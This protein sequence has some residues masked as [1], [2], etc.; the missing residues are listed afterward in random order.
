MVWWLV[1]CVKTGTQEEVAQIRRHLCER[2]NVLPRV[3]KSGRPRSTT[4][5]TEKD[6]LDVVNG[7]PRISPRRVSAR[8]GVAHF[9]VWRVLL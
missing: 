4:A 3:A 1:A 2:G 9:T 5:E 7:T 8:V 6:I